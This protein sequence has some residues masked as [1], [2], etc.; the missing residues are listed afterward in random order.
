MYSGGR[1]VVCDAVGARVR[2]E[3]LLQVGGVAHGLGQE[4]HQLLLILLCLRHPRLHLPDLAL[5]G[6]HTDPPQ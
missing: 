6:L 2:V 5:R 4:G 1:T 3:E